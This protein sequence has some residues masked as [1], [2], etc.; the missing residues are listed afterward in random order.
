MDQKNFRRAC[1]EAA[2][3]TDGHVTE[4]RSSNY[5][6]NF[7]QGY[8][9]YR[10]RTVAVLWTRDWSANATWHGIGI[11][12]TPVEFGSLRFVDEPGLLAVLKELL[13][14]CRIFTCAELH[15]PLDLAAWPWV[16]EDDVRYWR[17]E[18]LGEALFNFWD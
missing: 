7:D 18:N 1:Y 13:P 15:G 9:A 2:R 11:A 8:L 16:D 4:F 17:P 3:R 5:S 10:H 14:V 6:P 12:S